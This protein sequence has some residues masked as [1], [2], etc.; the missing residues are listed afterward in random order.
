MN[1]DMFIAFNTGLVQAFGVALITFTIVL[2]FVRKM[3][4]EDKE[5]RSK[6]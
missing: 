4:R 2:Y 6:K 3:V 5:S 1:P